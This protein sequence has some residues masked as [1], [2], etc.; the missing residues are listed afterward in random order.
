MVLIPSHTHPTDPISF[1]W[2]SLVSTPPP[3]WQGQGRPDDS[4]GDG[5]KTRQHWPTM[6]AAVACGATE[7][8][9][10]HCPI[11]GR[12]VVTTLVVQRRLET[13]AAAMGRTIT[14]FVAATITA[15][16]KHRWRPSPHREE[17]RRDEVCSATLKATVATATVTVHATE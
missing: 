12:H 3:P 7:T 10:G 8:D 13:A 5:N 9:G 11:K 14:P 4:D 2:P 16:N 1:G 6:M 15:G 17:A